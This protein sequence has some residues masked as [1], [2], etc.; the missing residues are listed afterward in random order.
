MV[1]FVFVC[2]LVLATIFFFV[3]G[4]F[5]HHD[6]RSYE[7]VPRY[8][9]FVTGALSLFI[10]AIVFVFSSLTSVPANSV[11]IVTAFGSPQGTVDSG[12]HMLWPWDSVDTYTTRVQV[13]SRLADPNK[14]DVAGADC[15]Q[16]NLNGGASA[17]VDVTV[18]YVVNKSDAVALWQKYGSFDTV[19]DVFL[20]TATNNAV[21]IVYG[22]YTPQQVVNGAPLPQ[23]AAALTNELS[24]QLNNS[25]LTLIAISPGQVWLSPASQQRFD[26]VLNAQT[27][28]QV[29]QQQLAK[30]RALAQANQ[31]LA[32]S[33]TPPVL[34]QQCIQAEQVVKAPVFNCF[35]GN[36]NQTTP[37]VNIGGK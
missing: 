35:P 1:A 9:F 37:L 31:A 23:I 36:T 5:Y 33:L 27:D 30:N 20:R 18:R 22:Q 13:T 32:G 2:L 17:C 29:A 25:G 3:A 6:P 7:T 16:T 26:D 8:A 21:K 15:V 24:N 10:G 34:V 19:R 28:V 14:G 12:L 4:A 11:G